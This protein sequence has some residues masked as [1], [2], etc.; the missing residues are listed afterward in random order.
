M[1][2]SQDRSLP[3]ARRAHVKSM[4]TQ[5]V[6]GADL[7]DLGSDERQVRPMHEQLAERYGRVLK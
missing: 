5:M 3:F 1:P 2:V 4:A 7:A 6:V